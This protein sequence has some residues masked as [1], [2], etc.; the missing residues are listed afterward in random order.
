MS[1]GK[2]GGTTGSRLPG[3]ALDVVAGL[4]LLY[5][6]LPIFVIVLY[7]F[8]EPVGK[9]NFVWKAFSLRAWAEPLKYP[10]LVDAMKLSLAVAADRD[11]GGN[12]VRD[13]CRAGAH[14]V[15]VSWQRG[16]G[17]AAADSP[18]GARSGPGLVAAVAL[19][20]V[21]RPDGFRDDRHRA[22]HVLR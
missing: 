1:D 7:S 17:H 11:G 13:A 2:R 12:G 21:Q 18:H 15:P 3:R 19:P 8:N 4:V 10:A 9:F 5:L 6:F 22:H 16:G 20:A 14:A